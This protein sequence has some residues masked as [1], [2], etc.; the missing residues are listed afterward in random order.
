M[1]HA[2]LDQVRARLEALEVDA[3]LVTT[4]SNRRWVS[5]FTGSAGVLLISRDRARFATDSRYWEQVGRQSPEFEL[6]QVTGA[7]TGVAADLLEDTV[8][9]TIGYEPAHLTMAAYEQ[10]TAAVAALPEAAGP[11]LVP[12]PNAIE[13]LRLIKDAEE[14]DALTRAVKLGDEG[15]VHAIKVIEPGMTERQLAWE[16]Q[17]YVMEHGADDL[18]FSTIVAGGDWGSAPHAYPRDVPL[19]AGSGV[20]IDMGVIVD[21]YCSDLTRTLFL[22]EPDDQFKRVYDTV[23]TA[24]TMAEERVEAGM[25]G[26]EAHAIAAAVIAEAGYGEYFG[27]GLGHGVGLDVHEAPRLAPASE[28]ILGDGQVFTVEPGIYIPGWG[29]VRIEDQC[30]MESGRARPL[31]AAPKLDLEIGV[32]A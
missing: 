18:S 27:H 17:R 9:M 21:G 23:L 10:W 24:Q 6:V 15:M 7:T 2:R 29:G 31:S 5:G 26:A 20:V 25:T 13:P 32:T 19:P 11:R 8:D 30:V 1:S 16:I 12:A 4:P 3:L 14:L 28:A 22:G